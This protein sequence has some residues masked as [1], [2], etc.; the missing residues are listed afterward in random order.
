MQLRLNDPSYTERLANFLR[1]LGQTAAVSGPGQLDVAVPENESGRGE[2]AIYLR[3]WNVLYP[4]TEVHVGGADDDE[5][6]AV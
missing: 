3:V 5:S 2:L 1:S 4:D 6:P